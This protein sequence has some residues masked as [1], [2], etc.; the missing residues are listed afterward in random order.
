[1]KYFSLIVLFF[2]LV[3]SAC[4]RDSIVSVS[5]SGS[6]LSG[7]KYISTLDPDTRAE[8]AKN[9]RKEL[10]SLRKWDYFI[11]KNNPEDAL[12]YYLQVEEKLPD[13]IVVKKKIAHAY[14]LQKNWKQAYRYFLQVPI[15]ELKKQEL[16]EL[17]GSLFFDETQVDRLWEIAKF[18]FSP[19]QRDYYKII[20]TCYSGIHNCIIAIE[21]YSWASQEL[22]SLKKT[23]LD[24]QKITS[25]Y[26]F[27]NF[28]VAT[29]FYMHG[30][31]R[32]SERLSTE[33]LQV[34]PD[35]IEVLKLA[36]FSAFELGKFS[37]AKTLLLDYLE[38]NPKDLDTIIK[39]WEINYILGDYIASNLYLNNAILAW[40]NPKTNLE[41]RLAYNYYMLGDS[42]G[43]IKVISYL[44][45]EPDVV[46]D[47]FAVAIS[48]ALGRGE[49]VRAFAWA[50]EGIG[51][52][53][54]SSIIFPL[55]LTT[56]RLSGQSEQALDLI[57]TTTGAFASVPV[58]AL[59]HG[60]L[61][62]EKKQYDEARELFESVRDA[63][64][65]ADFS[66]EAT[67]LLEELDRI[68]KQTTVDSASGSSE[69]KWWF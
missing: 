59:E 8:L 45:Q 34:R 64:Q 29:E 52:Y 36:G 19:E 57:R 10:N 22:I 65:N 47:D 7:E 37:Q 32:A 54:T 21:S 15:S 20:D 26:Q 69:K 18:S 5:S 62:S 48:L 50:Q 63:D 31:F 35:Y 16:D 39:L 12:A 46:E 11:V 2:V 68:Q 27:R 42:L 41:R 44:L 24:S 55:Y 33:I 58:V 6:T 49:N 1:M 56:L 53:P 51:R 30:D 4:S 17:V 23:S 3:T 60:I 67:S 43:M 9:R 61:L 13:D 40:V 66:L 38:K 28:S 14:Y 25:D